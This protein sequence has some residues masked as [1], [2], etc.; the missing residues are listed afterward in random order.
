MAG[1]G[2]SS[3]LH[4]TIRTQG[5][6]LAGSAGKAHTL[7]SQITSG[8]RSAMISSRRGLT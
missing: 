8:W 7:S 6:P 3:G 1:S 5:R 2:T 4:E